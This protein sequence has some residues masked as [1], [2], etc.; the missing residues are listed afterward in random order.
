MGSYVPWQSKSFDLVIHIS[1]F[2]LIILYRIRF[3]FLFNEH[4]NIRLLFI[5]DVYCGPETSSFINKQIFFRIVGFEL[6]VKSQIHAFLV[7]CAV[8][9]VSKHIVEVKQYGNSSSSIRK[10]YLFDLLQGIFHSLIRFKGE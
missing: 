10:I 9:V 4:F 5:R 3:Y 1:F 8:K 2:A 7:S 6:F